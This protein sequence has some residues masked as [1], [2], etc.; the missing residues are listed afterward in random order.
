MLTEERARIAELQEELI[1]RFFEHRETVAHRHDART[2]A[3]KG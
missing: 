3:L 2:G 1:D